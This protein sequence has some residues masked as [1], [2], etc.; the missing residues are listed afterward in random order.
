VKVHYDEPTVKVSV[1]L[2]GKTLRDLADLADEKG[3]SRT[4]ALAEA[5]ETAKQL[6]ELAPHGARITPLSRTRS[7]VARLEDG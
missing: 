3:I 5:V 1:D 2:P 4:E 6:L 7:A